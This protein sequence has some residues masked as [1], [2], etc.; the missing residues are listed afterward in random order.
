MLDGGT[1]LAD[2]AEGRWKS[3]LPALGIDR[4][5]LTGKNGPCPL[6]GGKD[7][8]RWINRNG[9]GDWYCTTCSPQHG[10]GTQL[11]M[12]WL[13]VGFREA[14]NAIERVIGESRMEKVSEPD[15][16]L[17][18][19]KMRSLWTAARPLLREGPDGQYLASRGLLLPDYPKCLRFT[20]DAPYDAERRHPAILALVRD[21]RDQAIN[22]HRLF[23]TS[24]GTKT[25]LSPSRKLMWGPCPPGSAIRLFPVAEEL[26]VAEGVETALAAAQIFGIPV[27]SVICAEGMARFTPPKGVKHVVIFADNDRSYTGQSAAFTLA[28]RVV[29]ECGLAAH[30]ELAP[31]LG[32]DWNDELLHVESGEGRSEDA[33]AAFVRE[34]LPA[35]A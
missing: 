9:T 15:S 27:W 6:C 28:R 23:I 35:P 1:S 14:A 25:T 22:V 3:I 30:V 2:R 26:G 12:A 11:V 18:R 8:W 32:G 34:A 20:M 29:C 5:F 13:K 31:C 33:S 21:L 10:S 19:E 17:Q 16:G 24:H 4:K 7:R